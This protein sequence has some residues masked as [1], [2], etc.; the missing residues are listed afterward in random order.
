VVLTFDPFR[1]F[2]RLTGQLLGTGNAVPGGTTPAMPMN[3]YRA[4]DHF[5]QHC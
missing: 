3:R 5:V 1:E 2:E 4:G